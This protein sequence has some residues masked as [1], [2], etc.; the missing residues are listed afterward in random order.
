MLQHPSSL[1]NG[2]AAF[3]PNYWGP[4]PLKHFEDWFKDVPGGPGRTTSNH[5]PLMVWD[6]EHNK[7][8]MDQ[9]LDDPNV[10]LAL[11]IFGELNPIIDLVGVTYT[12]VGLI[13]DTYR[14][15]NNLDNMEKREVVTIWG[16]EVNIVDGTLQRHKIR[17]GENDQTLFQ[18]ILPVNDAPSHEYAHDLGYRDPEHFTHGPGSGQHAFRDRVM[19]NDIYFMGHGNQQRVG[20][21]TKSKLMKVEFSYKPEHNEIHCVTEC[22]EY[23]D[24]NG[25]S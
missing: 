11:G 8:W 16:N 20:C 21:Q 3:G 24:V 9:F 22:Y 10:S 7:G 15:L 6:N 18:I 12:A 2:I 25:N 13:Q 5:Y 4:L 17:F 1:D 23:S 19:R 14:E